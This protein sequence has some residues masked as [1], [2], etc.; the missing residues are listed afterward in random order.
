MMKL[1]AITVEHKDSEKIV[2]V[3]PAF[4]VN[5]EPQK[6]LTAMVYLSSGMVYLALDIDELS[7]FMDV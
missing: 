1:H 7:D 6:D 5:V 4:I 3:N 2:W